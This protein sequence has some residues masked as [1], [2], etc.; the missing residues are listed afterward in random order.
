MVNRTLEKL[1][2]S[3]LKT[4]NQLAEAASSQASPTYG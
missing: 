2:F 1:L 4:A 3:P